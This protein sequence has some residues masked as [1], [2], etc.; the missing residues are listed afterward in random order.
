MNAAAGSGSQ[1]EG[2][3]NVH[4]AGVSGKTQKRSKS[5]RVGRIQVLAMLDRLVAE[6][7]SQASLKAA[8]AEELHTNPL[9]FFRTV[10]MPLL[11]RDASLSI[12]RGG[13]VQWQSLLGSTPAQSPTN[14]QGDLQP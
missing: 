3:T 8:L 1:Q 12:D 5:S 11:P 10:I 7:K 9:R 14:E 2:R 13:V 6:K 4:K